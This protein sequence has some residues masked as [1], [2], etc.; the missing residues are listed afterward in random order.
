VLAVPRSIDEI[1]GV[2]AEP[3]RVL[4]AVTVLLALGLVKLH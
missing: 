1:D 4:A 2:Y 3:G